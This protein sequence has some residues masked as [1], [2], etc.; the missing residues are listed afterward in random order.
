MAESKPQSQTCSHCGKEIVP[1]DGIEGCP[2]LY[3]GYYHIERSTHY[4]E[5]DNL[6]N[7]SFAEFSGVTR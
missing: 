2:C 3:G 7:S 4:C 6:E 1:C 5:L